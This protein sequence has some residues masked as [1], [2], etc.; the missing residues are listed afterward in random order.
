[1]Q[2]EGKDK[3][4]GTIWGLASHPGG[5]WIGLSGGGG[6]GWLY[7]WKDEPT[8]EKTAAEFHKLKLPNTGRDLN[9]SPDGRQ[10]SVAHA[11]RHL[12]LY[13]LFKK[14]T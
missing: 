1:V 8:N 11:D 14:P 4:N 12:R 13:G 5:F 7:F 9:L 10:F 2:L 6:G 3:I